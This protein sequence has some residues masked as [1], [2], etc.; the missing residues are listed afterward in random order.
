MLRPLAA[1]GPRFLAANFPP[2]AADAFGLRPVPAPGY[3]PL[4][5]RAFGLRSLSAPNLLG[6]KRSGSEPSV[7]EPFGL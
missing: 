7:L 4:R 3:S 6:S 1:L 5:L 2:V